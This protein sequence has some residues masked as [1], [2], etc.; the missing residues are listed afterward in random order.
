[1]KTEQAKRWLKG[2]VI[3]LVGLAV[4]TASVLA[5]LAQLQ[6]S[7]ERR[8]LCQEPAG[9]RLCMSLCATGCRS[10]LTSGFLR[11]IRWGS[12]CRSCSELR[13]TG[14]I[15]SLAGHTGWQSPLKQADPHGPGDAQT[16]Y[17]TA[18]VIAKR[19][20]FPIW[21]NLSVGRRSS[22]GPSLLN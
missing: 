16:D 1:M 12:D 17:L 4:L 15:A 9:T 8:R 6:N 5:I 22:R 2:V 20:R 13:A 21:A 10:P 18:V 3:G 11:M 19:K 7:P 14:S